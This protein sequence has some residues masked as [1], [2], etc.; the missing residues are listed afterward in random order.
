MTNSW[1]SLSY[2]TMLRIIM[3]THQDVG[4]R[5]IWAVARCYPPR[6]QTLQLIV[7]LAHPGLAPQHSLQ[8]SLAQTGV[9]TAEAEGVTEHAALPTGSWNRNS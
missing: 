6:G 4:A 5:A 3:I 2:L 9:M 8:P 7:A 1:P